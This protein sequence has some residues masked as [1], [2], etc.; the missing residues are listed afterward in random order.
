[1]IKRR[2]LSPAHLVLS[3]IEECPLV[4]AMLLLLFRYAWMPILLI[5]LRKLWNFSWIIFL[6]MVLHLISVYS[7][8][9]KFYKDAGINI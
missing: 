8:L 4:C 2:P 7:I 3:L 1:M 9:I 6:F 5:T